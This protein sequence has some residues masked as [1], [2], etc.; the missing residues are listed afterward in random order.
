MKFTFMNKS[1]CCGGGRNKLQSAVYA[2]D[3]SNPAASLT[4][5][6]DRFYTNYR[7]TPVDVV[8]NQEEL[9]ILQSGLPGTEF[10]LVNGMLQLR[11]YPVVV[12]WYVTNQ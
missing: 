4:Q 3:A 12:V 11:K 1:S 10:S 6:L 2:V 5:A 9:T 7:T 8:V